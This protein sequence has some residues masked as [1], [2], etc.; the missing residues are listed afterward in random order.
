MNKPTD[1]TKAEQP[2]LD[3]NRAVS[4]HKNL[5]KLAELKEKHGLK[6]KQP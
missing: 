3:Y 1:N 5:S 6:G 4:K 2:L